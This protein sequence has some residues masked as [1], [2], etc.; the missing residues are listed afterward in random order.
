LRF[1]K[2]AASAAGGICDARQV[3]SVL[4]EN[5][6]AVERNV[7][8]IKLHG[9]GVGIVNEIS[10]GF[11]ASAIKIRGDVSQTQRVGEKQ[12]SSC[13]PIVFLPP[14]VALRRLKI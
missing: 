10:G 11:C 8:C 4:F 3:D 13:S 9:V 5:R 12:H 2:C 1:L 14:D 6:D 7:V